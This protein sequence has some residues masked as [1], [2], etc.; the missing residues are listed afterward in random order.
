MAEAEKLT[1]PSRVKQLDSGRKERRW[2]VALARIAESFSDYIRLP[3]V[4]GCCDLAKLSLEGI[5]LDHDVP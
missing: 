2:K 4:H 5:L 3:L 1:R